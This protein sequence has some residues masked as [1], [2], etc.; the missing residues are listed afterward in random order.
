MLCSGLG[1]MLCGCSVSVA[2][3]DGELALPRA[4]SPPL[5]GRLSHATLGVWIQR[6]IHIVAA[7]DWIGGDGVGKGYQSAL[8]HAER[9]LDKFCYDGCRCASCMYI[10][11][12]LSV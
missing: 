6:L 3:C 9:L 1:A 8:V 12:C 2:V 10:W 7:G 11:V 4:P 5:A